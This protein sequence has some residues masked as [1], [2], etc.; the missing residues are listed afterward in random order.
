MDPDQAPQR[1]SLT[2]LGRLQ[3]L[4]QMYAELLQDVQT[5][6]ELQLCRCIR[7]AMRIVITDGVSQTTERKTSAIKIIVNGAMVASAVIMAKLLYIARH[8]WRTTSTV[9]LLEKFIKN[10]VWHGV[11]GTLHPVVLRG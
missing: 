9:R 3:A 6:S 7:R 8:A 10:Y 2:L 11:F 4:V 1:N 5:I